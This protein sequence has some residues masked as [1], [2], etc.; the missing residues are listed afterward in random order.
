[1]KRMK[2]FV[3]IGI[4]AVMVVSFTACGKQPTDD[5][6]TVTD[7][8]VAVEDDSYEACTLT[9]SWWGGDSRHM[10]TLEAI[11][12]FEEKYPGI[13]VETTYGAWTNWEDSMAS[14]FAAGTAPD[15]NQINWNWLYSYSADGNVFVD[16]NQ[17]SDVLDLS[18][19]PQDTL[20]QCVVNGKLQAIPVSMTGRI[21]YWNKTT[22]EQAG[23]E[24]PKTFR[25]LVSAGRIFQE[26]LGDDYYPLA[27]GE[28][29][30]MI[31]MVYCLESMYGKPWVEDGKLQ[32]TTEEVQVG[33]EFIQMLEAEHVIPSLQT[34]L[35]DGSESFDQN[36]K[37]VNGIYAG[38]FEW[39]SSVRKFSEALADGQEFVVGDYFEDMGE[40]QGGFSKVSLGFAISE[41]CEHKKEAAMLINFLLN[42]EEGVTI[43]SS[44]R[45]IPLSAAAFEIC[46]ERNLLDE[47]V[48]EANIRVLDWVSFPLDFKFESAALRNSDGIYYDTMRGLSNGKYN[49]TEASLKLI[50]G[51]TAELDK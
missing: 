11:E 49:A 39:D 12:A 44:E 35:D 4:M 51:V 27:L 13:R 41:S 2:K 5:V 16:L 38:I 34:I 28:Y 37:W 25:E 6:Q 3:A 43:M 9:C 23:I 14:M 45:G 42:E 10:A 31:L 33:F 40:F 46:Q 32:Y 48:A 29:D 30:R 47:I 8:E 26:R 21:F 7:S 19:F 18:Q 22:F 24:V 17:V 50:E 1:M 20:D 36:S 15:V